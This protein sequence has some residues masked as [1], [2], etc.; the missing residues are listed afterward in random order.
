TEIVNKFLEM[1]LRA[2]ISED[3]SSWAAWLHIL[4]FAYNSHMSA[5]TGATPFLL[6]LGFQPTSPLDQIA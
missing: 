5:S 1:M 6:L 4:E 3:K 2:Y